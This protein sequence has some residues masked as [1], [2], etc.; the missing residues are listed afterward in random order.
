MSIAIASILQE[1]N[2][3]SPVMT[4]YEDF[5]PVFGPA[6]L[7]RHR[8]KMTEMGGF[9]EV[10]TKGRRQIAPVCAA[11]AI[12]ANRLLQADFER[13][14]NNFRSHLAAAG[15][16]E[17]LLLAMHGAQTAE[18]VD[19]VEG[20]VLGCAREILGPDIPIVLTLDLHANVTRAMVERATAIVGYHTYPHIDMYE[21]GQKAA[22]MLSRHSG[23]IRPSMAWRKLPLH[24][25]R[26]KPADLAWA[27]ASAFRARPSLRERGQSRSRFYL[28][29]ATLDGY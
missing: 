8:G 16:P 14:V 20:H 2:T 7:E 4:R 29:G 19:D 24:G 1:A 12:T 10:L 6:V 17:G 3:F 21:V 22:K 28:P 27:G 13:L 25:Q 23:K 5:T 26:R 11:W 18:G 9:I 15:K